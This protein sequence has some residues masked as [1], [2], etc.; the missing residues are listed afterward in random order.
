MLLHDAAQQPDLTGVGVLGIHLSEYG[1]YFFLQ[2]DVPLLGVVV[3]EYPY[4]PDDPGLADR[5][6]NYLIAPP[7]QIHPYARWQP[8]PIVSRGRWTLYRLHRNDDDR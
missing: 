4:F 1:N 7:D 2:R 8:E 6:I 5:R 3:S